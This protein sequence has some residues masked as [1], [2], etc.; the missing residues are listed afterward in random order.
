MTQ[1]NESPEPRIVNRFHANSDVDS[2]V[3]AQHHTLGNLANQGSPGNHT[4]DGKTSKRIGA[5][6][7]LSFPTTAN[8]AYTQAQLQSVIDALRDLGFGS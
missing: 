7:D 6:L 3:T 4:H 2:S 5:G 1:P 8:G